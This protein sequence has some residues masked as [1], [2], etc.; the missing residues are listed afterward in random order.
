MKKFTRDEPETTHSN[1][2]S[3]APT[4]D[5]STYSA[6]PVCV[7]TPPEP[8]SI[9]A[10]SPS[11]NKWSIWQVHLA[12]L[13]QRVVCD[14]T[15]HV[16]C[17]KL[18]ADEWKHKLPC[19]F[20]KI[21]KWSDLVLVFIVHQRE[22]SQFCRQCRQLPLRARARQINFWK[23]TQK[24]L[25]FQT[26]TVHYTVDSTMDMFHVQSQILECLKTDH[27]KKIQCSTRSPSCLQHN[28]YWTQ[29]GCTCLHQR[30]IPWSESVYQHH[31]CYHT[32][33]NHSTR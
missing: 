26:Q 25:L 20:P 19:N 11:Y 21:W 27:M 29:L 3:N 12:K 16:N 10:A 9:R 8:A 32:L 23:C 28:Q 7:T 22:I 30:C 5:C 2:P 33:R 1:L 31:S 14:G 15:P 6:W 13:L 18:N 4:V 24:Y 17:C